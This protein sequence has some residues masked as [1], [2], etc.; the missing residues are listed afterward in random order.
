M[1]DLWKVD[2]HC[3]TIY[4]KDSLTRL[5]T[6]VRA[7]HTKGLNRLVVTDHNTIA[8]GRAAHA[9]DPQMIIVG[10]E[11]KTTCGEILAAYV[12]EEI[13]AGLPPHETI[14]RLREQGAFI[15]VS[16]PFDSWRNGDWKLEDLQ[17]ITSLVDAIEI[18]NARCTAFVDNQRS[19]EYA[20]QHGLAGTAGS[21]AHTAFELGKVRLELPEFEGPDELRKVLPQGV[22][23]GSLSPF[24]VHFA[25]YYARWRKMMV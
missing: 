1:P 19:A 15:S 5:E 4:S 14:Q 12:T 22:V 7:G 9:L 10:E 24:W 13:P 3:H 21:D 2:F 18:F 17:E 16:H 8:G 20:H 25:S 23:R 6:L 11:I